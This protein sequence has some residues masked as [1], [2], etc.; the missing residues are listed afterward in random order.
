MDVSRL[1]FDDWN[2][3]QKR[4]PDAAAFLT[5][6]NLKNE[7]DHLRAIKPEVL[8]EYERKRLRELSW[9]FE[10]EVDRG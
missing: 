9:C 3:F 5:A 6:R 4:F 7:Y 1:T 10:K 8:T 2:T